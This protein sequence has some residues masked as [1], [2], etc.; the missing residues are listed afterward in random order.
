MKSSKEEEYSILVCETYAEC[1]N[2][3]EAETAETNMDISRV[4]EE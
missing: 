2:R 3:I 1:K 4:V